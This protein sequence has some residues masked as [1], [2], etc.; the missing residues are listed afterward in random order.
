[1]RRIES[2]NAPVCTRKAGTYSRLSLDGGYTAWSAPF[3]GTV[4]GDTAFKSWSMAPNALSGSGTI[5]RQEDAARRAVDYFMDASVPRQREESAGHTLPHDRIEYVN[6]VLTL[7]DSSPQYSRYFSEPDP[8]AEEPGSVGGVVAVAD[9]LGRYHL[10]R[11]KRLEDGSLQ[12]QRPDPQIEALLEPLYTNDIYANDGNWGAEDDR[13]WYPVAADVANA[14]FPGTWPPYEPRRLPQEEEAYVLKRRARG[15]PGDPV[16]GRPNEE[17]RLYEQRM[18][19][20]DDAAR[21]R[22]LPIRYEL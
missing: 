12:A 21:Q 13:Q 5:H 16:T 1:M 14:A 8:T 10:R 18:Q 19:H 2:P 17:E 9:G 6:G 20:L 15:L 11:H 7:I 4:A 3:P 22:D